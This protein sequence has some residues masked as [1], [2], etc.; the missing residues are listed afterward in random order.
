MSEAWEQDDERDECWADSPESW[1]GDVH[2]E[3]DEAWRGSEESWNDDPA[4]SVFE[5][6]TED[7]DSMTGWPED[8]AG[9][10]YWLFKRDGM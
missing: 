8:M 5:L 4:P 3:A 9:P 7:E 10:E 6:V 1:R 2:L